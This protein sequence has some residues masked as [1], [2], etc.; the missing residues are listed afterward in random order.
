MLHAA[1]VEFRLDTPES[2]AISLMLTLM[3]LAT[4]MLIF[5]IATPLTE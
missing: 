2:P 3:M 1:G 4:L 5:T